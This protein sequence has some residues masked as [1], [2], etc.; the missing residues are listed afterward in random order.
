MP[1]YEPRDV[2]ESAWI[3]VHG[4][5][6]PASQA[7]TRCALNRG[8]SFAGRVLELDRSGAKSQLDSPS[9]APVVE[10][11]GLLARQKENDPRGFRRTMRVLREGLSGMSGGELRDGREFFIVGPLAISKDIGGR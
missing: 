1:P 4:R 2:S 9:F 5:V 8:P 7:E 11:I 3:Y 6:S 10:F